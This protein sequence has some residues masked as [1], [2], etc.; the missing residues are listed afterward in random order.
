MLL[1]TIGRPH[2]T[3]GLPSAWM[4]QLTVPS[5]REKYDACINASKSS[6]P[7]FPEGIIPGQ[8]PLSNVWCLQKVNMP[9][10]S[11]RTYIPVVHI[12]YK[13]GKILTHIYNHRHHGSPSWH[14]GIS[15]LG[16]ACGGH[17]STQDRSHFIFQAWP[18]ACE[19]FLHYK[20]VCVCVCE[21][22][23][24]CAC[25]HVCVCVCV[26]VCLCLRACV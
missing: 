1:A 10:P 14:I 12:K 17:R 3:P 22:V 16:A 23:C 4:P 19:Y 21:C 24:L 15:A 13:N 20:I 8:G 18:R 2:S 5:G 11:V 25:V 7:N 9:L 6:T 26:F